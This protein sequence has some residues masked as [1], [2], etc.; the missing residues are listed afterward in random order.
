MH[1]IF[2]KYRPAAANQSRRCSHV[3]GNLPNFAK[4]CPPE[5]AEV[6]AAHLAEIDRLFGR[7]AEEL[8]RVRAR[9]DHRRAAPVRPD[10]AARPAREGCLEEDLG[11]FPKIKNNNG[12][13]NIINKLSFTK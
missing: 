11:K 1:A 7:P 2:R 3:S 12:V 13:S 10:E 4:I 8:G 5:F 6:L 9:A